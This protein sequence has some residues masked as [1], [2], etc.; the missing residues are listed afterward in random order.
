MS[1]TMSFAIVVALGLVL[2]LVFNRYGT[3]KSRAALDDLSNG[4]K[5]PGQ[6]LIARIGEGAPDK[7]IFGHF[8]MPLTLGVRLIATGLVLALLY[9]LNIHS[10]STDSLIPPDYFWQGYMLASALVSWYMG[11]VWTYSLMLDGARLTVPTWGFGAREYDL[12]ELIRIEDDGAFM[13]RL[14]FRE[15]D[16]AEIFKNV[17]GRTELMNVLERF[18]ESTYA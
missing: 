4:S 18:T 14:Y 3:P 5:L 11:Y 7:G 9:A 6:D 10:D 8:M 15:G 1:G 17:R 13:V 12:R 2:W 16:K